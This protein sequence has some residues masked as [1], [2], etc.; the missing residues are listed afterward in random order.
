MDIV[1][2]KQPSIDSMHLTQTLIT[3]LIVCS[4][5]LLSACSD[6]KQGRGKNRAKIV[7]VTIVDRQPVKLNRIITGTLESIQ[8]VQIRNEEAAR[9]KQ[10]HFYEGDTVEKDALLIELDG[11]LIEAEL[12]KARASLNQAKLDLRRIKRLMPSNL[13]SQDQLASAKTSLAQTSAE[14]RLLQ[15]R[16]A[17]TKIRAP[18]T[19]KISVRLKEPGDVV[20]THSHILTI[21]NPY[22]LK[23]K[24]RVSEILLSHLQKEAKLKI[25]RAHV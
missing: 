10:I 17:H 16:L 13:A 2:R 11:S 9:I 18:F 24:L 1:K 15:T 19:G 7:E 12:D 22:A 6:D 23:A 4:L 20:P 21:I 14:T 3:L 25:G 5:G 8:L